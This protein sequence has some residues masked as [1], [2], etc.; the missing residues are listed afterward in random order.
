MS[1]KIQTSHFINGE[2]HS[3]PQAETFDL[4][5]PSTEAHVASI[6][7]ATSVDID[8]AV[9]YAKEGQKVWAAKTPT[10]RGAIMRKFG[11][12]IV[13]HAE[14]LAWLEAQVESYDLINDRD[15]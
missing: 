2:F 5:D 9:K 15:H 10:E 4:Y 3:T 7:I 11:E 6:P 13:E 14:Q 8:L 12:S 1:H